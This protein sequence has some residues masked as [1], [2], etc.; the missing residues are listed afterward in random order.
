M[1]LENLLKKDHEAEEMKHNTIYDPMNLSN[2]PNYMHETHYRGT[3]D[4]YGMV[5]KTTTI[6]KLYVHPIF[7]N[8]DQMFF[9]ILFSS[10]QV[11]NI[12]ERINQISTT[13]MR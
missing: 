6:F 3:P 13:G 2:A 4:I 1:N 8:L 11:Q 12:P 9:Y 7:V 5:F 10:S